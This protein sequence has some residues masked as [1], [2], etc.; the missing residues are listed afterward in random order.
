MSFGLRN[1]AQTFQRFMD[2]TPRG[3]GGGGD[4]GTY[5]SNGLIVYPLLLEVPA[6][7]SPCFMFQTMLN[8]KYIRPYRR[9]HLNTF[10]V[11]FAAKVDTSSG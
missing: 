5:H 9:L 7:V 2:D 6:N 11:R 3:G 8:R 4:V 1:V 10:Y